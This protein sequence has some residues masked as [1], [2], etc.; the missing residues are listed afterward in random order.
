MISKLE[1][2]HRTSDVQEEKIRQL[3]RLIDRE[4]ESNYQGS[5]LSISLPFWPE[6]KVRKIVQDK[7]EENG[8]EVEF[9][10]AE[11]PNTNWDLL[12]QRLGIIQKSH[13]ITLK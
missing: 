2:P 7:Y 13:F 1:S 5:L 12:L 11:Q 6:E 4:I 8:W 3:E 9:F 10:E